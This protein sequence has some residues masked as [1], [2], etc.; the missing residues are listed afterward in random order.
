M[1]EVIWNQFTENGQDFILAK[2]DIGV[3]CI[4]I[5]TEEDE[6]KNIV[7]RHRKEVSFIK[8]D[9]GDE[10]NEV[11]AYL[12]GEQ[13]DFSFSLD[14]V[15]TAFQLDVWKRALEIPYGQ[16]ATYGEVAKE[17][18][19]SKAIRAVGAALGANPILFVVPCHRVIAQSGKLTGYRAGIDLKYTL[20]KTENKTFT[21][22]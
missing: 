3:C 1:T 9:I 20:L 17:I 15:G 22:K 10:A 4:D 14:L 11:I 21:P 5:V 18:N 2:S 13:K 16:T 7:R 6:W 19:R 12:R 8:G